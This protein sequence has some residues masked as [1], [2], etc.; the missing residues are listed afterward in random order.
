MTNNFLKI[1]FPKN[2]FEKLNK[3]LYFIEMSFSMYISDL[4]KAVVVEVL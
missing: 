1:F 2:I 3:T 4:E